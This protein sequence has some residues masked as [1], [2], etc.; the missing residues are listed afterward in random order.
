MANIRAKGIIIRQSDYG[1]GHRILSIFAEGLGIIKAVSYGA[2]KSKSALASASQFLC[3]GTFDLFKGTK[4][5][6]NVNSIDVTESFYSVCE[7]IEK[8][9]LMNYLSD[10]TYGLLGENNADD[11]IL[12]L[13]LNTVYA[14]A[15]R[16][17]SVK[18]IKTVYELK[19]M[20]YGGYKPQLGNC[21][22][23]NEEVLC[24][25][26]IEKGGAVCKNCMSKTS[27]KVNESILKAISY[28]IDCEDKKMLSFSATDEMIEYLNKISE[29]YVKVQLDK[30]FKSLDYYKVITMS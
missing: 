30:H 20:A 12:R 14:L 7:D 23:C 5:M 24:G 29:N 11:T 27:V 1:E 28:I 13:Y 9:A 3:C 26:D 6:M 16:K 17:E 19:L 18:K 8:L 22:S 2:G 25:F 10:I 21:V 15:Y 4:N